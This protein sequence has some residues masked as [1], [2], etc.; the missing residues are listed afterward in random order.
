K[1]YQ[2]RN[3]AKFAERW[4]D[5]L[6]SHL[7]P[8]TVP[9]PANLHK[10]QVLIVDALT[11]R[12]DHD[13][14]SLRLVNLMR[15]LQEEGAH[16]VFLPANRAHDGEATLALQGMGVEAWYAPW[17]ARAPAWFREHGARFDTIVLC[18][19]YVAS[20]FLPLARKHAPQARVVF[21]TV[22]L[23]YLRERRGAEV[24]G[25]QVALRAAERTR[26]REL[27]LIANSDATLVVSDVERALLA[28]DAPQARVE[29]LSNLHQV[30]GPGLPF[31][32]RRDLVFVG[33]F[34][35]PPNV[36]A[37]RWFVEAVFPLVR[38]RLP[39]V[40]FHCIGGHVPDEVRVLAAI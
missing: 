29:V 37:V 4:R 3:Q 31:A 36:D 5:A 20:E 11:P 40:Q 18:R 21:D 34:R 8:G 7:P 26:A 32:Q 9:T 25:D 12:P 22:D 14:G 16:V 24:T 2:V 15:L 38:A 19:H 1:A 6:A 23:H 27:E 35:H 28:T 13:S 10:R 17:A 33:G 39:D 30:A